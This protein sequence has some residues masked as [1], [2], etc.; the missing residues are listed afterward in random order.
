MAKKN[1]SG[2]ISEHFR[3]RGVGRGGAEGA[4]APPLHQKK[5][6]R[7]R[8]EEERKKGESEKRIQIEEKKLKQSF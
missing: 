3:N 1:S 5:G 4:A 8:G 7:E 6:K 2:C